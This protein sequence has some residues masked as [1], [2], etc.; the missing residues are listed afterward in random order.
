MK[1]SEVRPKIRAIPVIGLGIAELRAPALEQ[2][3]H[4]DDEKGDGERKQSAPFAGGGE[5]ESEPCEREG[6]LRPA[7]A[8]SVHECGD[9]E[10]AEGERINIQHR[11]PRL[12][13]NHLIEKGEQRRRH[14]RSLRSKQRKTAEIDCY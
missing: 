2:T 5:T 6:A 10:Q 8:K 4:A 3:D 9:A 1:P 12:H 14:R 13:E 11:D 7:A